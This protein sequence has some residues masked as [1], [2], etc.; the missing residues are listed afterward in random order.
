MA[1][2]ASS[3][4]NSLCKVSGRAHWISATAAET[5]SLSS[6]T[7]GELGAQ[8]ST[9]T[10]DRYGSDEY[11]SPAG[12]GGFTRMESG[13]FGTEETPT[14]TAPGAIA[15]SMEDDAAG[16]SLAGNFKYEAEEEDDVD[17]FN[18]PHWPRFPGF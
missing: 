17:Y 6:G 7:D 18:G 13:Y 11:N 3:G 10:I 2:T 15:Q 1:L 12:G 8:R 5:H 14:R 9:F 4:R 16:A